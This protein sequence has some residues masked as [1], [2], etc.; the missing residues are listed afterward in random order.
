MSWTTITSGVALSPLFGNAQNQAGYTEL[1][2]Y[3]SVGSTAGS[4]TPSFR[5]GST[6]SAITIYAGL[7]SIIL[8]KQ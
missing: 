2:I 3:I 1:Q 8:E 7:T 4:F 6:G 5:S